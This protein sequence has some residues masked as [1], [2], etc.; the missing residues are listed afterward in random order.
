VSHN[1]GQK[2]FLQTP[3][4]APASRKI[5]FQP[6]CYHKRPEVAMKSFIQT[7]MANARW[8]RLILAVQIVEWCE[9]DKFHAANK[10]SNDTE[11]C[12]QSNNNDPTVFAL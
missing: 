6:L 2:R 1:L 9:K 5:S 12:M 10:R 11:Q 3:G 7:P 4:D 8:W